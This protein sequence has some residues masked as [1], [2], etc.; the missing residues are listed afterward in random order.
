MKRQQENI[1]KMFWLDNAYKFK[2]SGKA[3]LK[4]LDSEIEIEAP[5]EV[6]FK[7]NLPK[8]YDIYCLHLSD[9][10]EKAIKKLREI[11]PHA[12]VHIMSRA[13]NDAPPQRIRDLADYCSMVI[14]DYER[15]RIC[16]EA[17][18]IRERRQT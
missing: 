3:I 18:K 12:F 11:N 9:T 16:E 17:K 1:V 5:E 6:K 2:K 13:S 4:R 15:L 7:D 10:S 14:G 8:D